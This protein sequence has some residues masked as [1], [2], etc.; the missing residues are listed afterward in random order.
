MSEPAPPRAYDELAEIFP[1]AAQTE[2]FALY[3]ERLGIPVVIHSSHWR[4]FRAGWEAATSQIA[5]ELLGKS[6]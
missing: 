3:C 4:D 2:A 6:R 1:T 5:H